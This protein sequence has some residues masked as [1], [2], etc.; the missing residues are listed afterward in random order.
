MRR[1]LILTA[2]LA[3]GAAIL[4]SGRALAQDDGAALSTVSGSM[5]GDRG[6]AH[7]TWDVDLP[8]NT[9]A[10]LRLSFWPCTAHAVELEVWGAGGML[11]KAGQSGACNKM[12]S[13]NTGAG[14]AA[15]IRFSNY[16]HNV[17][18]NYAVSAEGFSLPGASAP[19]PA[20]DTTAATDDAATADDAAADDTMAAT[21][22][23]ADDTMAA[24]DTAEAPAATA[25]DETVMGIEAAG[26]TGATTGTLLGNSGGAFATYDL[27][28]TAGTTYNLEM[29]RG[30]DA[31]GN[32][33]SVGFHVW[34]P[35][36]L[37]TSSS[38][39][40]G[41]NATASFTATMDGTYT[42]QMYNYH[43]GMTMF[44]ALMVNEGGM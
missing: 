7:A 25:G 39:S 40:H 19:A 22:A 23:A 38:M 37:V 21:D 4:S 29:T 17:S 31:G 33:P 34:S 10:T 36:G 28:V 16:M 14:G 5:S 32:W 42:V 9:D 27:P 6:G 1:L 43:H 2:V 30:M 8:A 12:L 24:A 18:T 11:G 26:E 41:S 44:Y 35:N 13:W 15:T 20:A 3:M